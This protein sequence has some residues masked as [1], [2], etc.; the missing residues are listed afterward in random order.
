MNAIKVFLNG[1]HINKLKIT[2]IFLGKYLICE[3][4]T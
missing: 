2:Y 3:D 4:A 1:T